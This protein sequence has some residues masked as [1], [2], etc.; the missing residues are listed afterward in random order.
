MEPQDLSEQ[1]TIK[2]RDRTDDDGLVPSNDGSFK[3]RAVNGK[4]PNWNTSDPEDVAFH[5]DIDDTII[6]YEE[7]EEIQIVKEGKSQMA[8]SQSARMQVKL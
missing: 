5:V 1:P 8:K 2:K 3:R 6:I 4:E 7:D